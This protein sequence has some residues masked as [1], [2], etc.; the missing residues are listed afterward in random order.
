MKRDA[1]VEDDTLTKLEADAIEQAARQTKLRDFG[2]VIA[3]PAE[4]I[5]VVSPGDL[6]DGEPIEKGCVGILFRGGKHIVIAEHHQPFPMVHAIRR[7][8]L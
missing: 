3:D 1:L 5:A 4:I 8:C 6:I 7:G 2:A